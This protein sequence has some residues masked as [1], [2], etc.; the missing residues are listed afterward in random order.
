MKNL[1]QLMEEKYR[2]KLK[3]DEYLKSNDHQIGGTVLHGIFKKG[4]APFDS[5]Q[6]PKFFR[7]LSDIEEIEY[8]QGPLFKS[9]THYENKE[10]LICALDGK[11]SLQLVH[12]IYRQ[13]IYAG[14][15]K[16][17]RKYD[18]TII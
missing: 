17:I 4:S 13:E 7:E 15:N 9:K 2:F 8:T 10:Q 11:I 12:Q 14:Q 1:D 6:N 3:Y 16:I 18:D 5:I